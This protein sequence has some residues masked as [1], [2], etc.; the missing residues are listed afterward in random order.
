[1]TDLG[2]KRAPIRFS[3]VLQ[4]CKLHIHNKNIALRFECSEECLS[5]AVKQYIDFL[6]KKGFLRE[7]QK[8]IC[9]E[10]ACR[11]H[12]LHAGSHRKRPQLFYRMS[13]SYLAHPKT[14]VVGRL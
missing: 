3:A 1:M 6:C 14:K 7:T 13:L 12:T 8:S 10:S 4:Q 2:D 9:A 11:R 5:E